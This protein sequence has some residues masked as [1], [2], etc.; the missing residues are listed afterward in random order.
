MRATLRWT[1]GQASDKGRKETN[2]DFHGAA[3][4]KEPLAS[5]KGACAAIADGI[6]T[7]SV[8]AEA[9]EAAVRSFLDD[10]YCTS[11]AWTV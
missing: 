11:E 9:S 10:Y 2:Q 3:L 6:S 7:S 4:P 1:L 8:S 5:L